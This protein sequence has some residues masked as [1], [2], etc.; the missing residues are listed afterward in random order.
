MLDKTELKIINELYYDYG[1][2]TTTANINFCCK[3]CEKTIQ[4]REVIWYRNFNYQL[5]ADCVRRLLEKQET[6]RFH[7][8]KRWRW[9]KPRNT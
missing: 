9:K 4:E 6:P 1:V 7:T 5:C 2:K 3:G 8:P